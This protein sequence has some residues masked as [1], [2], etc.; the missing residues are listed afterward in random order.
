MHVLIF[1]N[2]DESDVQQTASDSSQSVERTIGIYALYYATVYMCLLPIE[3]R[4]GE[5]SSSISEPGM[6]YDDQQ[7]IIL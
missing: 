4:E 3:E 1:Y 7:G 2:I 6:D 5:S